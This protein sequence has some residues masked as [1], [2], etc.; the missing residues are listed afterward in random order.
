MDRLTETEA[1]VRASDQTGH[2]FETALKPTRQSCRSDATRRAK[3]LCGFGRVRVRVSVTVG[4]SLL[5]LSA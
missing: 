5:A 1:F 4:L 2:V 3:N